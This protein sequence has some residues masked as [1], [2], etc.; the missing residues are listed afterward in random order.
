[1]LDRLAGA[2]SP[3]AA[4][5]RRL[6]DAGLPMPQ[7][8]GAGRYFDAIGALVLGRP[9][10]AFEGQVALAWSASAEPRERGAYPFIVDHS[11]SPWTIDLRR[12]VEAIVDDLRGGVA[13]A[14]ISARFHDTLVEATAVAV[15]RAAAVHGDLPVALGGGCFQNPRL[16]ESLLA[17]LSPRFD[18]Y[19]NR[20]VPPGDG[21]IALGQAAVAAAIV[22]RLRTT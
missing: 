8:H 22:R 3:P 17:R 19:R 2:A 6:L 1:M 9:R 20:R 21:G 18:I 12:M 16:V 11:A 13:A 15:E 10:S 5:V 4:A 14:A 7:A